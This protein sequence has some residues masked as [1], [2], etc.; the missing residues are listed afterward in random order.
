MIAV[1]FSEYSLSTLSYLDE[2]KKAGMEEAIFIRVI[3]ITKFGAVAGF[4]IDAWVEMQE[5]ESVKELEDLV[6][7]AEKCGVKAKFVY[8]IPVGDPVGEIVEAAK[9]E[10]ASL[11]MVASRGKSRLKEI[12]LG[13][14]S[15]GVIR[16]ADR[17]VLLV[18]GKSNFRMFK[19]ILYAHDLSEH[20]S[21]VVEYVKAGAIAGGRNVVLLHVEE[22]SESAELRVLDEIKEELRNAGIDVKLLIK[23][24][25]PHKV[26]LKTAEE[27]NATMI[28][29]ASRGLSFIEGVILGSTTDVVTRRARVPVFVHK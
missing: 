11:I 10:N 21:K 4:D 16:K 6:K 8:P 13:S 18:K 14:V 29:M 23:R 1:D 19:K 24:G 17:P 22:G 20:S 26:I 9:K 27:E 3:N 25:T 28:A 2:L 7:K 15:E 12:L 5:E